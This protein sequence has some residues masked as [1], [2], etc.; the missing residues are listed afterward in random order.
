LDTIALLEQIVRLH[1]QKVTIEV[2]KLH[3]FWK[4]VKFALEESFAVN[5]RKVQSKEIAL[6]GTT[7]LL[8]L[9]TQH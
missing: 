4:I 5:P 8:G 1:A 3:R 6:K 9:S 7:A 2:Q